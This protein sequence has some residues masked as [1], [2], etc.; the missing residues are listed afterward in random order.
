MLRHQ[1]AVT[2]RERPRAHSR[3]GVTGPG[4]VGAACGDGACGAPTAT[5]H[6]KSGE[7]PRRAACGMQGRL[8]G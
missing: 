2:R 4:V 8:P 6:G 1:L 5:R 7:R 3:F